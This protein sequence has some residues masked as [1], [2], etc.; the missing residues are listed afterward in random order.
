MKAAITLQHVEDVA[1]DSLFYNRDFINT[2]FRHLEKT[3]KTDQFLHVQNFEEHETFQ[4]VDGRKVRFSFLHYC[5]YKHAENQKPSTDAQEYLLK[6]VLN[7]LT[8]NHDVG[9]DSEICCWKCEQKCLA[10]ELT[11]NMGNTSLYKLLLHDGVLYKEEHLQ[12]AVKVENIAIFKQIIAELKKSKN[13]NPTS[14][15]VREALY[16]ARFNELKQ[17][18]RILQSEGVEDKSKCVACL[19]CFL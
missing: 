3:N 1:A 5:L 11:I 2:F 8:C 16:L 7:A 9:D 10:M 12:A 15:C 19:P 13:W 18:V 17:F 14:P 4:K 6:R